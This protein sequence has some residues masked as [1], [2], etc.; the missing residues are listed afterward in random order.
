M[1]KGL[2]SGNRMPVWWPDRWQEVGTN[3][4]ILPTHQLWIAQKYYRKQPLIDCY[5]FL[6]SMC[7]RC[8]RSYMLLKQQVMQFW[9]FYTSNAK[10]KASSIVASPR[11]G[12]TVVSDAADALCWRVAEPFQQYQLFSRHGLWLSFPKCLWNMYI[13]HASNSWSKH[14]FLPSHSVCQKPEWKL[15]E[16]LYGTFADEHLVVM[17]FSV[18]II[19]KDAVSIRSML[20]VTCS[21]YLLLMLTTNLKPSS[22]KRIP[23][24]VHL[25]KVL[26]SQTGLQTSCNQLQDANERRW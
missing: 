2:L 6:L 3:N 22:S 16:D 19:L 14:R 15:C 7:F 4:G 24:K 9:I 12:H 1:Y 18:V 8:R 17:G 23:I 11:V 21:I 26:K 5:S 13:F 25:W 20:V 10:S